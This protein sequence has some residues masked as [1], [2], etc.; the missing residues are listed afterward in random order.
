MQ[1]FV[2]GMHRSG[3]SALARI[4]NLM[5]LYFGDER[6]GTGRND[7][8]QKGF[9]ERRD[10]RTLNDTVLFAAGC[11][12]DCVSKFDLDAIPEDAWKSHVTSAG[13]IV[14]SLD[15]H[16]PWF[17]KEPRMSVLFP[18]WREVVDV[19]VCIHIH[20]NPL[21]VAD[22]LKARDGIPVRTG[23]ALWEFYTSRALND[24]AGIDRIFVSYEDLMEDPGRAVDKLH[25]ALDGRENYR[26]RKPTQLELARFLDDDLHR[27]RRT[28]RSFNAVATSSQRALYELLQGADDGKDTVAAAAVSKA[29]LAAL[30]RYERSVDIDERAEKSSETKSKLSTANLELQLTL[31]N[32]ELR[33][34]RESIRE[35]SVRLRDLERDTLSLRHQRIELKANVGRL[36]QQRIELKA[37][38]D[39][40]QQRVA[41][42]EG[43]QSRLERERKGLLNAKAQLE[44]NSATL[45]EE[46]RAAKTAVNDAAFEASQR[47]EQIKSTISG[48]SI[49][50][51]RRKA[52]LDELESLADDLWAAIE[53]LL[54][55]R[56]W[57]LGN[58]VVSI[59]R[60]L[61]LRRKT[62]TV[63]EQLSRA[64]AE[65]RAST[66][67]FGEF[68]TSENDSLRDLT[69]GLPME[70][71][72]VERI[73]KAGKFRHAE[74]GQSLIEHSLEL[75]RRACQIDGERAYIAALIDT[76]EALV[77]SRRWRCGDLLLSAPRR[78]LGKDASPTAAN[79]ARSLIGK[80]RQYQHTGADKLLAVPPMAPPPSRPK[81]PSSVSVPVAETPPLRTAETRRPRREAPPAESTGV[82]VVVCV[83]NALD[84]VRRCLD[85]VIA[86]TTVDY[87]L[88]VVND[89]SGA[90]TTLWLRRFAARWPVVQLIETG[91]PV[92]YTCAANQGLRTS[93]R[94]KVVLLNSD[95][96]VPRLWLEGLLL[97]MASDESV[98]LVGPL[99]NAASWQS[100]PERSDSQG[101]WAVNDLPSGY[102]VDEFSELVHRVSEFRFPRVAFLNGFCLLID[103]R[104]IDRVGYLDEESFPRGYGE[105]NDYCLRAREAGF[106]LAVADQCYVYHAKS[107]SFGSASRDKLAKDG[108]EALFRKYGRALVEVGAEA[109]RKSSELAAIRSRMMSIIRDG[110]PTVRPS[111]TR[112]DAVAEGG[113]NSVLFVLPVRGGSGGANSVVQEARG[114]RDLGVDA[115]VATNWQSVESM[116]HFYG[117]LLDGSLVSYDSPADLLEKAEPFDVIVATLWT[118]PQLLQPIAARWPDKLFAYYVQDYEPWFYAPD[119]ENRAAAFASYTRVAGMLLMAKTDWIC[120]TVREHHG[121]EVCR[122]SPSLDHGV[123]HPQHAHEIGDGGVTVLAMVRPVTPRRAPLR[124]LRVL[125]RVALSV[126]EARVVTFGCETQDIL[127]CIETHKSDLTLDFEFTNHGVLTRNAVAD[128]MRS[129][130]I[131]IDLSDYQAFGRT[132]LEAMA[133]GCAVVLP[134][135]GGVYE[136]AVDGDNACVVDTAVP[137]A[138]EDAVIRLVKD[139]ALREKLTQQG[140]ET[141][142]RYSIVRASLSELSAFRLAWR[143]ADLGS[144]PHPIAF[145]RG[146]EPVPADEAD[147]V[148]VAVLAAPEGTNP[149]V[150]GKLEQ[151]VLRPL[152]HRS[153]RD[154]VVV[155][156]VHSLAELRDSDCDV[157]VVHDA[158]PTAGCSVD[159]IATSCRKMGARL[160][161]T[162]G[163]VY[164][165]DAMALARAAD[166]AVV[167]SA[168]LARTYADADAEVRHVPPALDESLWLESSV[169]G[170]RVVAQRR[171]S[172][173]TQ[174][175]F[176]GCEDEWQLVLP[177]WREVLAR[178]EHPL[179][180]TLVGELPPDPETG[181]RVFPGSK[182][183]HEDYVESL[184]AHN[185]WDIAVLPVTE[186]SV[187]ADLRFLWLS[188]LGV[189]TVGSDRG[190]HAA[191]AR[192][193]ENALL[194]G[195]SRQD[196]VDGL[197]RLIDD[198]DLRVALADQAAYDLETGHTL[199]R[200]AWRYLQVFTVDAQSAQSHA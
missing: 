196:W 197:L 48:W 187:D 64:T 39:L 23:L 8:N 131:F 119:S 97:C 147:V 12:W 170:E 70:T 188:A 181:Y 106:E 56:R 80:Y 135:K 159:E 15:A 4:L 118:T 194:V 83:H 28:I 158:V 11:D 191:F 116:R 148:A 174:V 109:V 51:K 91:G 52:L 195:S 61:A 173:V 103:R 82:D 86:N 22:S 78:L 123:F 67:A 77:G 110:R 63:V 126:A 168:S 55:S 30:G 190:S 101:G 132:G 164:S 105:E 27:H 32:A 5:G 113:P 37:N 121:M 127:D 38:L 100:I 144:K 183:S 169:V 84:H 162:T 95:T 129:A 130:D 73:L 65:H 133:C 6:I 156:E 136:Y 99:S 54:A 160:V 179:T 41:T 31:R 189:A 157:C 72:A 46:L 50:L 92:G 166:R 76:F 154:R 192:H 108:H 171:G 9:W 18:V 89:G 66:R 68:A 60:R 59:V 182:S 14:L 146:A 45:E 198:V 24:S 165:D 128:L 143:H 34:A 85:S 151:R 155:R 176:I 71:P 184:R 178:S 139:R 102:N 88:I 33:H 124:T 16:R 62:P 153:L 49:E 141:A 36:R 112:R 35:R 193:G 58:A 177:A 17:V 26:L 69:R 140:L 145:R 104:V 43:E 117:E 138:V 172:D 47:R 175:L 53:S 134:A 93:S 152:R 44:M 94:G 114:M 122:V 90:A 199:N 87:R 163:D 21:A 185:V 25:G 10:V 200:Q 57:R 20:R 42:L 142:S 167:P 107:R 125:R 115:R 79:S 75:R 81:E 111:E 96:I 7:E 74:L 13:D 98:G 150:Q 29:C 186:S 1:V 120:R 180:L 149:V 161:C 19:P 40:S 2:L 137:D 3:T